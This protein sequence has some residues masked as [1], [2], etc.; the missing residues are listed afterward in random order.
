MDGERISLECVDCEPET[1]KYE[2]T[3]LS[4]KVENGR[5]KYKLLKFQDLPEHL[6]TNEYILKH[7]RSDWPFKQ[8][9]GS[10]FSIHNET[11]N[12]WT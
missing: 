12:V 6:R 10:L 4:P 5:K 1:C 8:A 7:Y 3:D 2:A 9:L 11:L